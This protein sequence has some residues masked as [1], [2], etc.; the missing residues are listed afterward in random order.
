[1]TQEEIILQNEI[2]RCGEARFYPTSSSMRPTI[3]P[4]KDICIIGPL[5]G[6]HLKR[7]TMVLYRRRDGF[8]TVNRIISRTRKTHAYRLCGDDRAHLERGITRSQMV[9]VVKA[10]ESRRSG[11]R[12]RSN[13]LPMRIWTFLMLVRTWFAVHWHLWIISPLSRAWS[14]MS[15]PFR[16][17]KD[18]HHHHHHHHHSA[19]GGG[20][21][22]HYKVGHGAWEDVVHFLKI[23]FP[24]KKATR[25][26]TREEQNR[27]RHDGHVAWWKRILGIRD[28]SDDRHVSRSHAE[29][30]GHH[31]HHLQYDAYP[32]FDDEGKWLTQR[33]GSF[34]FLGF[35]MPWVPRFILKKYGYKSTKSVNNNFLTS[36]DWTIPT[37]EFQMPY[38]LPMQTLS[39]IVFGVLI[40]KM[41]MAVGW[42][43][44]FL[45]YGNEN[46]SRIYMYNL[47]ITATWFP[48]TLFFIA[49]YYHLN[50]IIYM[51]I[52]RI[53]LLAAIVSLLRTV[54]FIYRVAFSFQL[55][56]V[57]VFNLMEIVCWICISGFFF[58]MHYKLTERKD[59]IPR[60]WLT[61]AQRKK[62]L[63][64]LEAKDRAR[65]EKRRQ[66]ISK[67]YDHVQGVHSEH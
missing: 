17:N 2:E 31:H 9:G 41:T 62:R 66:E 52:Q 37:N 28:K 55:N 51:S 33:N 42:L 22:L 4:R 10:I 26:P 25:A 64:R 30:G 44:Y 8:L 16:K 15:A 60:F 21:S 40:V 47:L 19:G 48:V 6:K 61:K 20:S 35:R 58:I 23:A 54:I 24:K 56:L 12:F 34:F 32:T 38:N 29:S 1:M 46:S 53:S 7:G 67:E 14:K 18:H 63:E 50:K 65:Q 27:V 57:T 59:F 36:L 43:A 45:L 13:G 5:P 11:F 39:F 49:Y 3:N